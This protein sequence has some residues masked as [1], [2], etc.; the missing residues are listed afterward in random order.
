MVDEA[1]ATEQ[2]LS[3]FREK[4][5]SLTTFIGDEPNS[6]PATF[7]SNSKWLLGYQLD[8]KNQ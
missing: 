4:K 3:I 6:L 8:L 1:R 5:N 2:I 7:K